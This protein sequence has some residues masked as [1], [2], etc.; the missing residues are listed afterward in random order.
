[1]DEKEEA[2]EIKLE[3]EERKLQAIS[4]FTAEEAK[5]AWADEKYIAAADLGVVLG[6]PIDVVVEATGNPEAGA[7]HG[8][9]AIEAG[10]H[11]VLVSKE[12]DSVIGPYL[13]ALARR[14]GKVVTPVDGDQP[15]LLQLC[16][17]E[18][19]I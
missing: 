6:L 16:N 14:Q 1:M 9:M 8:R 3:E 13:T 11:L 19:E 17:V 15:W 18:R 7:R 5:A 12:V 2:L 10:R 4:G